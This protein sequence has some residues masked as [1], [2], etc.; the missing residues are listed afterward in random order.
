V[1][2]TYPLPTTTFIDREVEWLRGAGVD[3]SIF[4][5]R[6]PVQRLS[7]RQ[8]ALQGGVTYI[9]PAPTRGLLWSHLAFLLTKPV[10]YARTFFFLC[11]RPHPSLRLWVRSILHFGLAV[12]IT[13][14][15]REGGPSDHIH[16]HFVDRAAL[17]ALV[18]S[19]LL[20]T[21]YS[22]TAH[23]NDIYVHPV[24][25]AEKIGSAKF[26]ATCTHYNEAHLARQVGENTRHRLR[27]I[28]HGLD[29][30]RYHPASR[31]GARRERALILGVGQLKE[32]KGFRYLL[33]ACRILLDRGVGFDCEIVGD[34]PLR[35]ELTATIERLGLGERV[36]LLGALPH[37]AVT[38][39]YA[40]AAVFVLP[41]VTASDGD[42]DGIPNV[43]L[44]AM[45]MELPV[46]S[47]RHS[48]IPEAVTDGRTGLLVPPADALALA[49]ALERL[50]ADEASR[51]RLG[52]RGRER[53]EQCF[54]TD[55]NIG[56]LLTEFAA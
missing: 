4:S 30:D 39:R 47:T 25:L 15:I 42:R 55:V 11:T 45:A 31:D 16:A 24:L 6:R 22:A 27:C 56:K 9:L 54:D 36:S 28:Y 34:G 53:V 35:D 40:D 44:E 50:L 7:A 33:E 37:E 8:E 43:I 14:L 38:G 3:V 13:R 10:A 12:H 1:I 2:G 29:V 26:V 41:C 23:A 5:V 21:P 17:I 51:T 32:K 18:A 20:G 49:D 46:V 52:R 19:R 48:G